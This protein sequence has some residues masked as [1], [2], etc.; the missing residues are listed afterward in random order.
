MKFKAEY[1]SFFES[2][3][4]ISFLTWVKEMRDTERDR[5]EKDHTYISHGIAYKEV[6]EHVESMQV[7]IGKP[8][9]SSSGADT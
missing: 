4:G 6:L 5:N 8:S 9:R 2:P 7:G 3:A 1:E